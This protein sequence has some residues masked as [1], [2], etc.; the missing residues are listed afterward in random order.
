MENS[1]ALDVGTSG[2]ESGVEASSDVRTTQ[3]VGAQHGD[4]DVAGFDFDVG[5]FDNF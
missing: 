4:M 5:G 3:N 2:S 1:I